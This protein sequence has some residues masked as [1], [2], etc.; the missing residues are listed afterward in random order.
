ML[1][2]EVTK[3]ARNDKNRYLEQNLLKWKMK[4]GSALSKSFRGK[5]VARTDAIEDKTGRTLTKRQAEYCSELYMGNDEEQIEEMVCESMEPAPLRSEVEWASN[6]LRNEKSP[7]I[8]NILIEMQKARGE[9][10]IRWFW[11]KKE[12]PQDWCRAIFVPLPKNLFPKTE[13]KNNVQQP[14]N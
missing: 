12:W 3:S 11:E 14:D 4:G 2:K 10:G 1:D 6:H 8:D 7:G 13:I 5:W 9:E